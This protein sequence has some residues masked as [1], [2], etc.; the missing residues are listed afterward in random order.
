MYREQLR[1]RNDFE[2]FENTR[3]IGRDHIVAPTQQLASMLGNQAMLGMLNEASGDTRFSE[4][5]RA[6]FAPRQE[7]HSERAVPTQ[8]SSELMQK[9]EERYQ[10]PLDGLKVFQD[11]G[12]QDSGFN[13][14]AQG[15]EIHL[16]SRL[17]SAEHERVALHEIGHV[18]QRGSG[19]AH[20]S[21]FVDNPALEQQADTGFVA[22]QGF[23]MPTTATG[24]MMGDPTNFPRL[25]QKG[26]TCGIYALTMALMSL[27]PPEG[28]F[29]KGEY[30][31]EIGDRIADLIKN[32]AIQ[33]NHSSLGE[34]YDA[35]ELCAVANNLP[36]EVDKEYGIHAKVEHFDEANGLNELL[37]NVKEDQRVLI[38]YAATDEG[39]AATDSNS[40][41]DAHAFPMEGDNLSAD[42][43]TDAHWCVLNLFDSK[44]TNR[45]KLSESPNE[46]FV[47]IREG[48]D[49][50]ENYLKKEKYLSKELPIPLCVPQGSQLPGTQGIDPCREHKAELG[51]NE[52]QDS[53]SSAHSRIS[54]QRL[55]KSNQRLTNTM[56]WS[57]Y[58]EDDL[59]EKSCVMERKKSNPK[60]F[61]A[62]GEGELKEDVNLKGKVIVISR[63]AQRSATDATGSKPSSN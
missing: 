59:Y 4:A 57:S 63:N 29:K 61:K 47:G 24:P 53:A 7:P 10:V 11:T 8:L 44:K 49:S 35:Y 46:S 42:Q 48:L 9:A 50:K 18:V 51:Q 52:N 20:G 16:D 21:G 30:Y 3:A 58:P 32:K 43:M 33:E 6:R 22:V 38:A 36:E 41:I 1:R 54:V 28:G 62:S 5:L 40:A 12:L 34:F 56:D 23:S 2:R 26:P 60:H 17:P 27:Y 31:Q 45:P 25:R 14:Y 37:K 55:F 39:V 19:K 13:G 15:N